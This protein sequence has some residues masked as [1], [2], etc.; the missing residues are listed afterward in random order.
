MFILWKGLVMLMYTVMLNISTFYGH[1]NIMTSQWRYTK[2]VSTYFGINGKIRQQPPPGGRIANT[3]NTLG[4]RGLM[5]LLLDCV[6]TRNRLFCSLMEQQQIHYDSLE[7]D[8]I[9]P[10]NWRWCF[11]TAGAHLQGVLIE[12]AW[13][14]QR[15]ELMIPLMKA[16]DALHHGLCIFLTLITHIFSDML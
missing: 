14:L 15:K 10:T 11:N 12:K 4:G 9:K 7:A 5:S 16:H 13:N 1:A 3:L 8:I 6:S 2:M